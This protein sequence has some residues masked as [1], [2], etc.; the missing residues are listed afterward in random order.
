[1][2][3][4]DYPGFLN[5]ILFAWT[6]PALVVGEKVTIECDEES[7]AEKASPQ[8]QNSLGYLPSRKRRDFTGEMEP[9]LGLSGNNH[10]VFPDQGI[11]YSPSDPYA[12]L[13]AGGSGVHLSLGRTNYRRSAASSCL[14]EEEDHGYLPPLNSRY[15]A[16][17]QPLYTLR[18]FAIVVASL[19]TMYHSMDYK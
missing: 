2:P 10:R 1:M 17:R 9:V 8:S 3:S 13:P 15:F 14:T 11:Q 12:A 7:R 5:C 19:L 16:S 4:M 18:T 6:R